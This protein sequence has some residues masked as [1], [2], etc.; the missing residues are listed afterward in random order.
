MHIIDTGPASTFNLI[1]NSP[2]N[3]FFRG[4]EFSPVPEPGVMLLIGVVLAGVATPH[5]A[6]RRQ[7]PDRLNKEW[8]K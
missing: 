6:D 3:T 5:S 4:V 2:D 7:Q 1:S 8:Q